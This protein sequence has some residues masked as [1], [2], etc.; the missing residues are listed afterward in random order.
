MTLD[1]L[2]RNR[3]WSE[4]HPSAV[5][6]LLGVGGSICC[7]ALMMLQYSGD[8][9]GALMHVRQSPAVCRSFGL[10]NPKVPHRASSVVTEKVFNLFFRIRARS[11]ISATQRRRS[12]DCVNSQVTSFQAAKGERD[13]L[14]GYWGF[15]VLSSKPRLQLSASYLVRVGRLQS[16]TIFSVG[17]KP[18]RTCCSGTAVYGR[19]GGPRCRIHPFCSLRARPGFQHA[20]MC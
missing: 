19:A 14:P 9:R 12:Q 17:Q 11:D 15:P 3:G 13:H 10:A 16:R 2:E 20:W 8:S 5:S 4:A 18:A 1:W 7:L 6:R